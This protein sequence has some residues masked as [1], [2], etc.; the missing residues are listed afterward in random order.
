M[1]AP[2]R[3]P[4]CRWFSPHR[5][6][7]GWHVALLPALAADSPLPH[8]LIASSREEAGWPP[9][10]LTPQLKLSLCL[11]SASCLPWC[12]ESCSASLLQPWGSRV[13]FCVSLKT[14]SAK[15][16]SRLSGELA[17]LLGDHSRNSRPA[18]RT[19]TTQVE[20]IDG[21]EGCRDIGMQA[22]HFHQSSAVP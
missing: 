21:G 2:V 12:C 5:V 8:V 19:I 17:C 3:G 16:S 13:C 14:L 6:S 11:F 4:A 9:L 10:R 18:I 1:E 22:R 7:E 20:R 15:R